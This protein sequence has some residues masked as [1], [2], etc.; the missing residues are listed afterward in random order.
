MEISRMG[1]ESKETERGPTLGVTKRS[2]FGRRKNSFPLDS[3][4]FEGEH[5]HSLPSYQTGPAMTLPYTADS[6][7]SRSVFGRFVWRHLAEE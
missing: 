7:P 6:L 3:I 2:T 4:C 1:R 5:S